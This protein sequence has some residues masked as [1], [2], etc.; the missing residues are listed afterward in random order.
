MPGGD[1]Q[2]TSQDAIQCFECRALG[3]DGVGTMA[4]GHWGTYVPCLLTV[5]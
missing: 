4:S 1:A 2:A 3:W 5:A